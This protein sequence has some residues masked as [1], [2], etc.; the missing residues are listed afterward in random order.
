[1]LTTVSRSY[2][3]YLPINLNLRLMEETYSLT[4]E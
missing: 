2:K 3:K 1:L 4:Q